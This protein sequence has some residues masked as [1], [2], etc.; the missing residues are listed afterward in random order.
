MLSV[1]VVEGQA[2]DEAGW[3]A[4]SARTSSC[5]RQTV[6][7]KRGDGEATAVMRAVR[8]TPVPRTRCTR[9]KKKK[10]RPRHQV[11]SLL[12]QVGGSSLRQFQI[13]RQRVHDRRGTAV[14]EREQSDLE[15]WHR[16]CNCIHRST[17]C[18][19]RDTLQLVSSAARKLYRCCKVTLRKK[20]ELLV[21]KFGMCSSLLWRL[22]TRLS[23]DIKQI[24]R[25]PFWFKPTTTRYISAQRIPVEAMP[26][27]R[28]MT[29][30]QSGNAGQCTNL[31]KSIYYAKRRT[32]VW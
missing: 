8:D 21:F 3:G 24:C 30:S 2:G 11:C 16:S 4:G 17:H 28:T 20:V 1:Y 22:R 9:G 13:A 10:T 29:R 23:I 32:N 14:I 5:L 12:L 31:P 19:G 25:Q 18:K 7:W 6:C 15:T 26:Q 27:R